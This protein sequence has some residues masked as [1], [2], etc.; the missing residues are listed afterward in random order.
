MKQSLKTWL[1]FWITS[2][3]ITTLGLMVWLSFWTH[4]KI[5]VIGGILTIAI[6]DACSDALWIHISQESD[7]KNRPREIRESTIATF[8]AKFFVALSFAIPVLVLKDLF[9]ATII[10]VIWWLFLLGF[11]SRRIAKNQ[12]ANPW[13]V[14]REHV[15]IAVVVIIITYFVWI[16]ISNTFGG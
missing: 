1:A 10:S 8:V 15:G 16:F 6:A 11:L 2:W 9:T 14:I 7:K 5:A 3:I 12:K 13:H 4:L